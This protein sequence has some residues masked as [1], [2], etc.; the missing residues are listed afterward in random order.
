MNL[1]KASGARLTKPKLVAAVAHW[2]DDWRAEVQAELSTSLGARLEAETKERMSLQD[3]VHQLHR[4]LAEAHQAALERMQAAR[5]KLATEEEA[6]EAI[7]KALGNDK[8]VEPVGALEI[9]QLRSQITNK[10]KDDPDVGS[11]LS[12]LD[13]FIKF[14]YGLW[15]RR[16]QLRRRRWLPSKAAERDN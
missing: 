2:R 7:V 16:Q 6:L 1:L 9:E 15:K 8:P 14:E 13:A 3:Q 5:D 11:I 12:K 4:E 10:L